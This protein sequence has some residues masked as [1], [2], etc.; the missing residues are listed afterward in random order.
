MERG[1]LFTPHTKDRCVLPCKNVQG[2]FGDLSF[3]F[4]S[5][6]PLLGT[7]FSL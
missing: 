6:D 2:G 7:P 3:W 4:H 5:P 1:K